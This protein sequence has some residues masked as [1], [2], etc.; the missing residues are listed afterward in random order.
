MFESAT[1]QYL[2]VVFSDF[3]NNLIV[4]HADESTQ[5]LG[6]NQGPTIFV[7]IKRPDFYRRM[8]FNPSVAFGEAFASE[9]VTVDGDP[10]E[11][12]CHLF[13][14]TEDKRQ[15]ITNSIVRIFQ[16]LT[17]RNG[18]VQSMRNVSAHYDRH[19][20]VVRLITGRT[21]QYSCGYFPSPASTL[22]E[23]QEA[24]IGRTLD[25]LH[26]SPSDRLLDIGCGYGSLIEAA[27]R[28]GV[29]CFGITLSQRQ[30]EEAKLA[31][32][33]SGLGSMCEI[34][35][36]DYRTVSE[37]FSR[38]VSVGMFEHV[39]ARHWQG[40]FDQVARLLEGPGVFVLHTCCFQKPRPMDG[41]IR[42]H[43]FPGSFIPVI[44]EVLTH[45]NRAGLHVRHL[46]NWQSHYNR[47]LLCWR[48]NLAEHREEVEGRFGSEYYR[49]FWFYLT[50]CAASFA[51]PDRLQICQFVFTKNADWALP[52]SVL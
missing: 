43:I 6:R 34:A 38:I 47:T 21:R 36:Q 29:R 52:L 49:T 46:E 50:G 44:G 35:V 37:S 8:A 10:Y 19:D 33:R 2:A 11:F 51:A 9:D 7:Y 16:R 1:K 45:A 23:A 27:G 20:E 15:E 26:L 3:V 48:E 28:R 5:R 17:D 31:L 22:D 41:F 30:A 32:G 4:R 13:S 40:F 18:V 14:R 12:F 24:K 25:K 39:G 42:K